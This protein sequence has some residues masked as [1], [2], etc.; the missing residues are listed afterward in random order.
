MHSTRSKYEPAD[1]PTER[2]ADRLAERVKDFALGFALAAILLT[3]LEAFE[4]VR[5]APDGPL[6][7]TDPAQIRGALANNPATR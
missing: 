6:W 5:E 7:R 4:A 1:R 3:S 2:N